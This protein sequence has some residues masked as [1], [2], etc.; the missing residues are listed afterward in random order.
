[1]VPVASALGRLGNSELAGREADGHYRFSGARSL[2]AKP[3]E[4]VPDAARCR[5]V[6]W[7]L[8]TVS[9]RETRQRREGRREERE[10][11]R[12]ER[13]RER[14]ERGEERKKE[15]ERG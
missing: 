6:S 9:Q 11:E 5:C 12:K 4:L 8:Q 15:R 7:V 2:G 13:E 3:Q 1:M 14:E 10:K